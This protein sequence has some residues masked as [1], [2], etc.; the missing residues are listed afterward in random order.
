M[1]DTAPSAGAASGVAANLAQ[2][3]FSPQRRFLLR[4]GVFLLIVTGVAVALGGPLSG[5][6][7]VNPA[8]NGLIIG[9]LLFGVFYNFRQVLQLGPEIGWIEALQDGGPGLPAP[10]AAPMLLAPMAV[11]L[12]AMT[13]G[14]AGG[15]AGRLRL[16]ATAAR[17]ILDSVFIRLDE[18]RDNS[19]Y[20]IG[21]LIFLGLLGTFWG[22]IATLSSIGATIQNLSVEGGDITAVFNQLK[23]GLQAPL[24][25]MGTAFS[26][27]LFGLSGSLVLGFL[28]LNASQA[29]NR[30]Y[31]EFEEWLSGLTR[32]AAGG[33]L[34]EGE[35]P[36]PVYIT[37][38][39]EQTADSV[40]RLQNVIARNE[41][42]RV[43]GNQALLALS[44]QL[45]AL[46]DRMQN[47][48]N[49]L[50]RF[51]EGQSDLRPVLERLARERDTQDAGLDIA[52]RQHLRNMDVQLSR[53]VQDVSDGRERALSELRSEIKLLTRTVAGLA[54]RND[55]RRKDAPG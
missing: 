53:L 37:A 30:F 40:E 21:L 5:A 18:S 4:M 23:A 45:A 28:D 32:L 17:A 34:S 55:E 14:T 7:A 42:S 51:A 29:Q 8:L 1:T 2:P 22:L 31:N 41:D 10:P 9:V 35:T 39:L 44:Q 49:M 47:E 12:G 48:Q 24:S 13:V 43:A 15:R 52:S 38:L 54:G 19:R 26:S 6:F 16:S 3:V 33:P 46:T 50:R 36:V 20:M 11:M 27:S 25:G